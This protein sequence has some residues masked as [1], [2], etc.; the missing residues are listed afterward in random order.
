MNVASNPYNVF[1]NF[2]GWDKLKSI[3]SVSRVLLRYRVLCSILLKHHSIC[4][5]V[6][7]SYFLI[8]TIWCSQHIDVSEKL[9][10]AYW[11]CRH[12]DQLDA[13]KLKFWSSWNF[14]H[15]LLSGINI[16]TDGSISGN[17]KTCYQNSYFQWNCVI[18]IGVM[19]SGW[20]FSEY[21]TVFGILRI[22]NWTEKIDRLREICWKMICTSY[23]NFWSCIKLNENIIQCIMF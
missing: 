15:A 17:S 7:Q 12:D 23:F 21:R 6:V 4:F 8:E 9:C 14:V 5:Q 11:V 19:D 2:N 13:R 16:F 18:L 3:R 20:H 10:K 22:E 1:Y